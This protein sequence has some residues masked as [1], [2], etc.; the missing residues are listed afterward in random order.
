MVQIFTSTFKNSRFEFLDNCDVTQI[1]GLTVLN[2]RIKLNLR[3]RVELQLYGIIGAA[4][5]P[6]KQQ[7]RIIGFFFENRLQWQV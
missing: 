6:D 3:S 2:M 5:H 1:I 7:I 4:R